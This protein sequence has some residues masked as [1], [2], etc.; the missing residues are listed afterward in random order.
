[1]HAEPV[2]IGSTGQR[3]FAS[4]NR[5]TEALEIDAA[6]IVGHGDL[7]RARAV[8]CLEAHDAFDRLARVPPR[9]G[10]LEPVID[11]VPQQVPQRR[12][13]LGQDVAIDPRRLAGDIEARVFAERPCQVAHHAR[14]LVNA[15]GEVIGVRESARARSS[16][17][18]IR[19]IYALSQRT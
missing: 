3:S 8:A 4:D 14:E 19:A 5:G 2:T 16:T 17:W 6:P 11:S 9:V 13:E 18:A 15:V 12:I 10:R 7:E 1:M